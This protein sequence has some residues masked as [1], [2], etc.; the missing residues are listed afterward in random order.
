[1][2]FKAGLEVFTV[3][4][5]LTQLNLLII[6][7]VFHVL[8][9]AGSLGDLIIFSTMADDVQFHAGSFWRF[10]SISLRQVRAY[11]AVLCCLHDVKI[12]FGVV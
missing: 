11:E 12:V 6:N 4:A 7:C 10:P 3:T 8:C 9:S 2:L 1:M 5:W